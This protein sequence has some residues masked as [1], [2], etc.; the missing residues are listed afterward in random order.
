M[1]IEE[2]AKI[3]AVLQAAY[4]NFKPDDKAAT[5]NTWYMMLGDYD[6]NVVQEAVKMFIATG[7]DGFAPSI[8]QVIDKIY[9][10]ENP[11]P[12]AGMEAWDLV[13]KAVKNSAYFAEREF[14][15]LPPMVQKAVGSPNQ[16]HEWA[17]TESAKFE[18]VVQ[19]NFLRSYEAVVQRETDYAKLPESTRKRL[20]AINFDNRPALIGEGE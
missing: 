1:S 7:R 17:L 3:L 9:M 13:S 20:E 12:L 11:A 18:T 10:I 4:P 2:T 6:Y 14:A 5:I 19:S 16:L 8:S 15:K